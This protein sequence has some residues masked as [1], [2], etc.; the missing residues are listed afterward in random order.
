MDG[1]GVEPGIDHASLNCACLHRLID[2]SL[3][4]VVEFPTSQDWFVVGCKCARSGTEQIN[5][6]TS[7]FLITGVVFG[8]GFPRLL[9]RMPA[10]S[11][12]QCETCLRGA[13]ENQ[14]SSG[15]VVE[16]CFNSNHP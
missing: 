3:R 16:A 6:Q 2:P 9:A 7:S 15:Q 5:G 13:G 11:A 4:P 8:H 12:R 14:G 1:G 10:E